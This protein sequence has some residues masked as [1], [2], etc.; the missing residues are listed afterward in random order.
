[1]AAP[2]APLLIT[3]MSPAPSGQSSAPP[4]LS[5]GPNKAGQDDQ[6]PKGADIGRDPLGGQYGTESAAAM[7]AAQ[8]SRRLFW[9]RRRQRWSMP[10]TAQQHDLGAGR[11]ERCSAL[12]R[13]WAAAGM[14][15]A[16]GAFEA[17]WQAPAC[18]GAPACMVSP[19]HRAERRV[20][21]LPF[22]EVIGAGTWKGGL[23]DR[24]KA[25][26]ARQG[27]ALASAVHGAGACCKSVCVSKML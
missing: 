20:S 19:C 14:Q 22:A 7:S 5:A 15:A 10:M 25:G 27:A 4:V 9:A 21:V 13:A 18:L 11:Q 16:Q 12:A 24:R 6:I 3:L 26:C 8:V 23:N 2:V 1:M 17:V